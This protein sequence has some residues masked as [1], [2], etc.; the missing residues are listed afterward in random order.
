MP[1]MAN[2]TVKKNDGT[3]DI[4]YDALTGAGSD[5]SPAT[6]RQDT[7]ASATLPVGLRAVLWL[8]SLWNGPKTA[9]KLP[10]RY[11]RPY[12]TQDTTT[13]RWTSSDRIVIEGTATIPYGIP[14][15]E[16]NEGVSQGCNLLASALIKDSLKTGYAPNQ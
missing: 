13:T 15:G 6:W 14:P 2:I 12:A 9:R 1:S 5:G 11:E 10:F 8:K 16:I 3:T 4:V 7:G